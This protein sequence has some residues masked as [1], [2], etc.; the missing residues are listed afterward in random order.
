ML[1]LPIPDAASAVID[2]AVKAFT[3]SV[4]SLFTPSIGTNVNLATADVI[5]TAVARCTSKETHGTLSSTLA[6]FLSTAS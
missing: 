5:V 2:E 1:S 4:R 6:S 3:D